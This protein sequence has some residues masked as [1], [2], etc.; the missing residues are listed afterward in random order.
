MFLSPQSGYQPIQLYHLSTEG[1]RCDTAPPGETLQQWAY[2]Y[3]WLDISAPRVELDVIP[4]NAVD[5]VISPAI[6]AFAAL[7]FPVHKPFVIPLEGPIVY[8]GISLKAETVPHLLGLDLPQLKSLEPGLETVQ[9]LGLEN[10][11]AAAQEMTSIDE[12]AALMERTFAERSPVAAPDNPGGTME[13]LLSHLE[14]AGIVKVAETLGVSERTFRR[15]SSGLMGLSPKKIQRVLRLQ[16][17]LQELI[18]QNQFLEQR[19]F[20]DDAHLIHELKALTGLTPSQLR[21]L[22]EIYNTRSR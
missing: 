12:V 3:W 16:R 20:Y 1:V 21:R 5:L 11:V 22:A 8:A 4:D 2:F 18:S 15:L 10:L 17:A 7:Y 14:P 19:G 13:L 6:P 9:S